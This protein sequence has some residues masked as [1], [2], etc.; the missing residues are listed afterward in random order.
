MRRKRL[1]RLAVLLALP[2]LAAEAP[3]CF[4]QAPTES[5]VKAAYIFNFLK[6][7]EWPGGP[8]GD[9]H[10]K[11]I[12]GLVGDS[13]VGEDFVRLFDGKQALGRDLQIKR[14]EDV[15]SMRACSIVFIGQSE[16]KHLASILAALRGSSI[17]T[18]SDIDRFVESGG[19]IQL[20]VEDTRVRMVVDVSAT[21]RARLK[22]SSKMLL[23]AR[24]V[25]SSELG[26]SN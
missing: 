2:L 9:P 24:V 1:T 16:K 13:P 22:V 26:A 11:W 3:V 12:I 23:L 17:L 4:A 10:A 25:G 7:V 21:T 5:Q 14:V 20:F 18:V 19:M 15:D 6:F 8:L